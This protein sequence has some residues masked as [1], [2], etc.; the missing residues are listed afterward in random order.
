MR[1]LGD[2]GVAVPAWLISKVCLRCLARL[3]NVKSEHLLQEDGLALVALLATG[4]VQAEA[5][6]AQLNQSAL[7]VCFVRFGTASKSLFR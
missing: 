6:F 5:S 2:D 1:S 3:C 4:A 7:Y